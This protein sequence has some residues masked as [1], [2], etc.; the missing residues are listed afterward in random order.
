MKVQCLIYH[1]TQLKKENVNIFLSLLCHYS[2]SILR[3]TFYK[4]K[5]SQCVLYLKKSASVD[6]EKL[7]KGAHQLALS[8]DSELPVV[9]VQCR[10]NDKDQPS[11]A[12]C[13]SQWL[14]ANSCGT[15][16]MSLSQNNVHSFLL[17]LVNGSQH[18][19]S[20]GVNDSWGLKACAKVN[21]K[22]TE[23]VDIDLIPS[24]F[25]CVELSS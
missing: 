25:T 9:S 19:G 20:R 21:Q 4:L 23:I 3:T 5:T 22:F 15:L 18:L 1:A 6:L 16:T 17:T 13:D 7:E 11:T 10:L 2:M 14:G 12:S 24:S 8:S